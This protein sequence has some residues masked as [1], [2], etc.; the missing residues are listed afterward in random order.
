[1]LDL[2]TWARSIPPLDAGAAEKARVRLNHLTKPEGSLGRLEDLAI[3]LAAIQ[4][5]P[6]PSV[7]RRSVLVFAA[8]HGVTAEGVSAY[9]R[10]VTPAMVRNFLAG[11]AAINVLARLAGADLRIV[12][13]GVD[14]DPFPPHERL[15]SRRVARGTQNL[16][17][18]DAMTDAETRS[19][20][21]TGRE[22]VLE[23]LGRGAQAIALGDMGI[24]NTTSA[25]ALVSAI[26]GKEPREVVG[27]GTGIGDE[28]LQRKIAVV[29]KGLARLGG[30]RE[31]LRVL[32]ALG[33][34]E[35]AA[36]AGAALEAASHRIPVVIDGVI[37]TAGA[38][39]A[40]TVS[41]RLR[42]FLI[43]AHL[44]QEP[45]HKAALQHLRLR[46]YLDLSLRLG[47]GT[48]AALAL[49]LCDASCRI[50]REMATFEEAAVAGRI[51]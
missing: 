46:P 32:S 19:A 36:I 44:S 14:A 4:G 11:G 29:E 49:L 25:S 15:I 1:M 23:A 50:L 51:L 13:V 9:P 38:L 42:E 45:G 40:T 18:E 2:E 48:G 47:E 12:D 8:D 17:R 26:T 16:A 3:Q 35:I 31:P 21:L 24:G 37:S 43:P 27:R 28:A 39:W 10:E 20:L 30:T 41:P 5:N 6:L 7:E 34:F 22:V 33:G